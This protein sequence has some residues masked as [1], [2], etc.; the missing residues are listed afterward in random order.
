MSHTNEN[1]DKEIQDR[2]NEFL[3]N[4]IKMASAYVN[5]E[6]TIDGVHFRMATAG[7]AVIVKDRATR[8]ANDALIFAKQ[9]FLSLK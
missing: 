6:K 9:K 1:I 7:A 5:C 4:Y 8:G 2:G 3:L